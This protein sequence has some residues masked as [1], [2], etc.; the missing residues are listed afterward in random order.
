M[1]LTKDDF[2]CG[3]DCYNDIQDEHKIEINIKYDWEKIR[4]EILKNQEL[5]TKIY[6]GDLMV[7]SKEHYKQRK[8]KAEKWDEYY[9]NDKD[10]RV[11][12]ERLKKRIKELEYNKYNAFEQIIIHELQKILGG[13]KEVDYK[14]LEKHGI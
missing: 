1:K 6:D 5:V 9:M 13:K 10:D 2:D 4:D 14:S 11:I 8:E 7:I 3:W 12:V